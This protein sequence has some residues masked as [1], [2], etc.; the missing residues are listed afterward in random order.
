MNLCF[1]HGSG[2]DVRMMTPALSG[3]LLAGVT[4]DSL[5]TI[6]RDLGYASEEGHLSTDD[7]Q[8][9]NLSGEISEVFACGTAAVITPVG[10]VKAAGRSWTV[11]D[12]GTGPVTAQLRAELLGIQNGQRLDRHG[13][14][15]TVVPAG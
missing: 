13:W 5:L 2:D 7:W 3:S 11:A 1:V 6:A 15:R 8:A 4:R 12:G 10:E 14:M 9:R